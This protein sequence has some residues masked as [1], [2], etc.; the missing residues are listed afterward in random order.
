[1]ILIGLFHLE[2][3]RWVFSISKGMKFSGEGIVLTINSQDNT[4]PII[5]PDPKS[6]EESFFY[7][8]RI[9]PKIPLIE[10]N[11]RTNVRTFF[12]FFFKLHLVRWYH[13]GLFSEQRVSF[14][15]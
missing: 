13:L 3:E 9:L 6:P 14:R 1:M 5:G 11:K 2:E 10:E 4:S 15:T 7:V 8:R 12:F